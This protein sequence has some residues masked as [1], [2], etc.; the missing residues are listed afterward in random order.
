MLMIAPVQSL[1][2]ILQGSLPMRHPVAPRAR[3]ASAVTRR[4]P[5]TTALLA[6]EAAARHQSFARAAQELSL[7]EGAISRQ[8]A[9]LEDQ[10]GVRLF[11]R[12]GNRVELSDLGARYAAEMREALDMIER[13]TRQLQADARVDAPL[14]IG[15]IPTFASRWLIPR[16]ARFHHLHPQVRINLRERTE[17]FALAESEL[18]AA[19]NVEHPAWSGM[20][21]EALFRAPLLAVCHPDLAE[22]PPAGLTLLHKH[23]DGE[24]WAAY[25]RHSGIELPQPATGPRYDRFSLLIDAARAGMGVALV[26]RLYVEEDLREGRLRAPWPAVAALGERY[27]LVSRP[28]ETSAALENFRE[29]LLGETGKGQQPG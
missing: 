7:T 10:V 2:K 25:A 17:P 29:W 27:V 6:L 28:G 1:P 3:T 11:H 9:K 13:R 16:M 23:E 8:I 5:G 21:I 26:P 20:Q 22:R 12:V 18:H 15:V 14:E 4:L 19:I 24:Q